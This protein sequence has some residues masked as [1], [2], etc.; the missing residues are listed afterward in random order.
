MSRGSAPRAEV[1]EG[2]VWVLKVMGIVIV[3]GEKILVSEEIP[4][5]LV[6]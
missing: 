1:P 3:K 2:L 6:D 4:G 5:D